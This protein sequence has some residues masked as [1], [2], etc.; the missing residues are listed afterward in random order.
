MVWFI[1][2]GIVFALGF[3]AGYGVRAWR[4]RMRRLRYMRLPP[5]L[6]QEEIE[7]HREDMR[8]LSKKRDERPPKPDHVER[9]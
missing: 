5:A 9:D 8:I 7:E 2:F 1:A 3:A 6:T 4:S